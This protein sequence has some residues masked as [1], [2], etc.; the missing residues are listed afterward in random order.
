[1]GSTLPPGSMSCVEDDDDLEELLERA[2][3]MVPRRQTNEG[4]QKPEIPSGGSGNP[5]RA[6]M[7]KGYKRA[8]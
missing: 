7:D 8:C 6:D 1:M 2:E 4:W 3:K 5:A